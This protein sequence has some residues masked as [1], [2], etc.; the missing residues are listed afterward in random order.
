[1]LEDDGYIRGTEHGPER[2]CLTV[3]S[4]G[5]GKSCYEAWAWSLQVPTCTSTFVLCSRAA[6][7]L[8]SQEDEHQQDLETDNQLPVNPEREN[9]R[10][11]S[12]RFTVYEIWSFL[13]CQSIMLL[14]LFSEQIHQRRD[15][16]LLV[17]MVSRHG[18]IRMSN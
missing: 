6:I 12:S 3:T 9:S 1:M 2:K 11:A 16:P 7:R 17:M 10:K 5:W 13:L 14:W 15:E 8:E 4:N 18:I